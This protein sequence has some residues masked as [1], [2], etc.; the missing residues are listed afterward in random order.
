MSLSTRYTSK[1]I[2]IAVD[3]SG[4]IIYFNTEDEKRGEEYYETNNKLSVIPL[5]E[6]NIIF[7]AGA[8][9]S[10]KSYWTN[11]Y[12][13][14]Y[15]KIFNRRI[16]LF[17]RN[18][19]DDTYKKDKKIYTKIL[20]DETMKKYDLSELK[21]SL[22]IFDDIETAQHPQVTKYLYSL[23]DDIIKNGRH[24][25][26][27]VIFCNQ[28]MRMYL[29]TRNILENMT[30]IVIFPKYTSKFHL[31]K[32]LR[33]HLDMSPDEMKYAYELPSRWVYI[34]KICPKYIIHEH[35]V[36]IVGREKY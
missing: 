16:I 17:T 21:N 27:S 19:E 12:A 2:P 31:G 18:E 23:M 7:V 25:N 26:I 3:N 4:T 9:N 15:K 28:Q 29:K 1:S 35:G 14:L 34:R 8:P 32:V 6:H 5:E 10:G 36:Y 22:V 24:E 20:I 11:Q 33:D 13:L 30:A